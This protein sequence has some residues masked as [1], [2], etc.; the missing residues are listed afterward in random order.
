M[1]FVLIYI[2]FF[3]TLGTQAQIM[4]WGNPQKL[5]SRNF[6][7]K[8]I[9]FDNDAYYYLRCKKPDFKYEVTVEK[10]SRDL[11]LVWSKTI[12]A[13]RLGESL[14]Q[15]LLMKKTLLII[16]ATDNYNSGF[17]EIKASTLNFEGAFQSQGSNLFQIKTSG[18][19]NND[20]E[21]PIKLRMNQA[22]TLFVLCY[23]TQAE[24]NYTGLNYIIFNE[25]LDNIGSGGYAYTTKIDRFV[26]H[27][28]L[29]YNSNVYALVSYYVPNKKYD[30][31]VYQHDLIGIHST[32][33]TISRIPV[34]LEGKIQSDLGMMVDTI[35][36]TLKLTGFY[37]EKKST[38]AA[39]VALYT[40]PLDDLEH[41]SATFT[42]FP[43][44]LLAKII[45][46][47][48]SEKTK[49]VE[50]FVVHRIIPRSD[51][52]LLMIAECFYIEKQA[53]N[54][55]TSGIQGVA[56][57]TTIFRNIYHYDEVLVFS[58][59]PDATIDWWQVITKN[60]NSI[61]DDGYNLSISTLVKKEMVFVFFN[62]NYHNSN[63]IMEYSINSNGKMKNK[64]LFKSTNYYI[65][66]TPRQCNQIA[67]GSLLM[68][69]IKDRKFNLLKLTY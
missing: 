32:Q 11:N 5:A 41:Y 57:Q 45:G 43:K 40:I 4:D 58:I 24:K 36:N 69:L 16:T 18:F 3:F 7:C 20:G 31:E 33:K 60:Q 52:G 10:Y 26:I 61:N 13:N 8:F 35:H 9:G 56:P 30:E 14:L 6:Y 44:E 19:Y 1:R 68:P 54:A 27:D 47:R 59:E 39:G 42:P 17:T 51:G 21:N 50:D 29:L 23:L 65:D 28:I 22:Q 34:L 12:N 38:S 25:T 46:E 2:L 49:E 64:I 55:Y 66:F 63:E 53:Y 15:V 37:S 62:L 67:T 48:A